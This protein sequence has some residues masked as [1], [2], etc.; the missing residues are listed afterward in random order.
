MCQERGLPVKDASKK[1]LSKSGLRLELQKYYEKYHQSG[2]GQPLDNGLE[3]RAEPMEVN[4]SS[5]TNQTPVE[6]AILSFSG[7]T[8]LV[9][10][11]ISAIVNL[12]KY[13]QS[14]SLFD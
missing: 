6:N 8:H 13:Q 1:P 9:K 7:S 5:M 10:Q 3:S 12:Y 14:V 2:G 11:W 4:Q